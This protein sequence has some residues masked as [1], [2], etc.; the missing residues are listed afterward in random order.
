[1]ISTINCDGYIHIHLITSILQLKD[2]LPKSQFVH[3]WTFSKCT[4]RKSLSSC[5]VGVPE[6]P[7]DVSVRSWSSAMPLK[8]FSQSSTEG[9]TSLNKAGGT[10]EGPCS[11][12]TTAPPSCSARNKRVLGDLARQ[13]RFF[14][15]EYNP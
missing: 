6:R 8:Y 9:P 7:V 13:H 4:C 5:T 10:G 15:V 1:M 14:E 2:C 12:G 11:V 3:I